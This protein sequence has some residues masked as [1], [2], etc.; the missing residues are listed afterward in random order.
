MKDTT[1]CQLTFCFNDSGLRPSWTSSA[2]SL[3]VCGSP[4]GLGRWWQWGRTGTVPLTAAG[5]SGTHA[6]FTELSPLSAS[7][8]RVWL[9]SQVLNIFCGHFRV[10]EVNWCHWNQ[11]LA[12]INEDPGKNITETLQ[13]SST[14]HQTV[15]GLRRGETLILRFLIN[16]HT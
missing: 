7:E 10:D 9:V 2:P 8:K 12:I 3:C 16:A 6:N 15:R 11:N 1:T 13:S 14:V 4:F 5:A